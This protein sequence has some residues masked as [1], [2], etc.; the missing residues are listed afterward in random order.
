LAGLARPISAGRP[1]R[2]FGPISAVF[3]L[4]ANAK[5]QLPRV[6]TPARLGRFLRPPKYPISGGD[7]CDLP[8]SPRAENL[9]RE[10]QALA[11]V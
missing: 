10:E 1:I 8:V 3:R 7:F 4:I 9:P 11:R 2:D 5:R 6:R